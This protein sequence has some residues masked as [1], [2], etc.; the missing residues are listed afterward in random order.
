MGPLLELVKVPLDGIPFSLVSS[1][2]LLRVHLIPLYIFDKDV[3]EH[4]SQFGLLRTPLITG[5][6]WTQSY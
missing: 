3:E 4:Q 5:L 6:H 1:S 2:N